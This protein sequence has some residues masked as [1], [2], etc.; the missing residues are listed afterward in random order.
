MPPSCTRPLTTGLRPAPTAVPEAG[1]RR[2]GGDRPG[3]HGA[4]TGGGRMA[5]GRG[6]SAALAVRRNC[7][8]STCCAPA[9]SATPSPAHATRAS[10]S[11]PSPTASRSVIPAARHQYAG[12][13][14]WPWSTRTRRTPGA[15]AAPEGWR[16]GALYP[17]ADLVAEI[18][19]ETTVI[20]GTPGFTAPVLDDPTP[21]AWSPSHS[22]RR[23]GNALAADTLLRS[24]RTRLLRLNG[25]PLPQRAPRT[26]GARIA[27]RARAVLEERMAEPPS[28]ERLAAELGTSPFALLRAFRDAVRHAAARLAHRRP[29]PPGTPPAR[30]G[31]R[32]RRSGRRRGLHRPAAPEPAL[33][34]DRGRAARRVPARARKNVQDAADERLAC[35]PSGRGRT[36]SS[37]QTHTVDD[38]GG[39]PGRRRR[40]GRARRR[41]RRRAVRVRLRGDPGRGRAHACCRPARSA[42]WSSPAP[43]SSPWSG[44]WRPAA[45]RSPPPPGAFFLGIATPSTGC[46]CR[47]CCAPARGAAVRRALG[48]RRDHRRRAGPARPASGPARLHRHRAHP[49]RAVEPHHPARRARRRGHRGHRTPG[50]WTPPDPPSSW[51]CSRRC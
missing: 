28:L 2:G 22:G 27:A 49:L 43:R 26:A 38:A 39:K 11:P 18:A 13:G 21:C 8:A 3:G 19:A 15:R 29:G 45:T 9:T 25:G 37:P 30:R 10:S 12:P 47:S 44:R 20:R 41:G 36:D 42:C 1:R 16:Y 7:P 6:E 32:A 5:A 17:S 40:A 34:P 24:R 48:H 51:P 23:E 4:G 46:G 35:L 14:T 50:A 31:H 33:H